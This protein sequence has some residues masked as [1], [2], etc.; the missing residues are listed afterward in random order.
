MEK[1]KVKKRKKIRFNQILPYLYIAPMII[2]LLVFS[3][4]SSIQAFVKSFYRDDGALLHEFVGFKN[5]IDILFKDRVFWMSMKNLFWFFLGMNVCCVTPVIAAKFTH[6]L[7]SEKSKFFYRSAFTITT[8]VPGVVSLMIWK[9]IY[10]PNVG[11]IERICK[12]FGSTVSPNLLGNPKTAV[13]AVIMIGFPWVQG[14][15]YLMYFAGF[16]GIDTSLLEAARIDGAN[17]RQIFF[18]IE[19]PEI[20][21]MFINMYTLAF[22]G[23]FQDYERF[24]ILTNGGPDNATMVPA[25]YMYQKAFGTPGNQQYGYACAMAVILFVITFVLSKLLLGKGDKK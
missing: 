15:A 23:Q 10:Y 1:I 6:S 11:M 25:L 14:L 7:R 13:L 16:Q 3:G 2:L 9:F 19:L 20:L 12:Y 17:G 24:M 8:V 5:Y 18:K 22:I 4:Y 21:P